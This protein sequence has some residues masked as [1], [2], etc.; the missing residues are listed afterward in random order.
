VTGDDLG[1]CEAAG[2]VEPATEVVPYLDRP[3]GI[4]PDH[5]DYHPPRASVSACAEH[6]VFLRAQTKAREAFLLGLVKP[7]RE[8][9][10]QPKGLTGG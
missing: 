3:S 9:P 4:S 2:C 1:I 7:P 5:P 8:R 10:D 6:G